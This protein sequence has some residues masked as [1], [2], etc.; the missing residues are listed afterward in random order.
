MSFLVWKVLYLG[1][2]LILCGR[3]FTAGEYKG[4][5]ILQLMSLLS[6][7]RV[8][9]QGNILLNFPLSSALH[10]SSPAM[11][12]SFTNT[13]MW[14]TVC[15]LCC[16]VVELGWK[17]LLGLSCAFFGT[18]GLWAKAYSSVNWQLHLSPGNWR[19]GSP[20]SPICWRNSHEMLQ[21]FICNLRANVAFLSWFL[22][23]LYDRIYF[24]KCIICVF[25]G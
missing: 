9:E 15:T 4:I 25:S 6:P 3:T 8:S 21:W 17:I 5:F 12:G 1:L 11:R 19:A 10:S 23:I 7:S 22:N 18:S 16:S 2:G 20:G 24:T 13:S 14:K